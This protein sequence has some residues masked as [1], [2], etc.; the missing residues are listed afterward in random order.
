MATAAPDREPTILAIDIGGTKLA[1]GVVDA[2][3]RVL[4]QQQRSTPIETASAFWAA[5]SGL[6]TDVMTEAGAAGLPLLDAVGVGTGGPMEPEGVTISPLNITGVRDFP[7]L[8]RLRELTGL[9]VFIDN[10]AKALALGEGAFGAARGVGNFIAMVVST[11][12]GGGLVLDGRLVD[13][14]GSNA[15]HI[16]HVNVEPDGRPCV[17]GSHGCLEAEASGTAIAAITGAPAADAPPEIVARTGRLV[18]RAIASVAN[19]CDLQLAVVSGSVAL[20]FGEPFFAAAQAE[21][22]MR[23]QL[24]FSTGT[25]I[26]PGELGPDG[27]LIGAAAVGLRGL[28]VDVLAPTGPAA[29]IHVS[30]R[31][32]AAVERRLRPAPT[33]SWVHLGLGN[34]ARAHVLAYHHQLR[35]LSLD[36][37]WHITAVGLLPIDRPMADAMAAQGNVYT[38]VRWDDGSSR[39]QTVDVIDRYLFAPDD[40]ES[41]LDA[42]A[43]ANIVS[44]T[45]TEG[46]YLVDPLTGIFDTT[47]ADV[48]ADAHRPDGAPPRTWVGFVVEALRRRRAA[49]QPPFTLVSCDNVQHN[50]RVAR[51]AVM[52]FASLVDDELA[53]WL[54]TTM[55]FPCT[56][57][58]RITPV[59]TDDQRAW[60]TETYGVED[61]RPVFSEP[62]GEWHVETIT[63]ERPALARVGVGFAP[64]ETIE[65]IETRKIRLLNGTHQAISYIGLLVGHTFCHEAITDP[66]IGRFAARLMT[67][68]IGPCVEPIPGEP[69]GAN[70]DYAARTRARFGNGRLRDTLDRIATD[71]WI[72]MTRFVHPTIVDQL[73]ADRAIHLLAFTVA[74]WLRALERDSHLV[75]IMGGP[76]QDVLRARVGGGA[77]ASEMLAI[78]DLVPNAVRTGAGDAIGDWFDLIGTR[79]ASEA[80]AALRIAMDRSG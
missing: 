13:G 78:P 9:G 31:T 71:S 66:D 18:G 24:S 50:G 41:V 64:L 36:D 28:G 8:A 39:A 63:T 23:A 59:T 2:S 75:D 6:V 56:M 76:C 34:F 69:G 67:D 3:G 58:D 55:A 22:D 65:A 20:G 27:P 52:G 45:I 32:Q 11:G 12:V 61:L 10:D 57:V 74:S 40:R 42:L 60:L 16:G 25:R 54:D 48:Q 38:W 4:T 53:G 79:G 73:V 80:R 21:I 62:Y 19:L 49:G 72:R 17:C 15:G 33:R 43:T 5:L 7:L 47:D 77:T 26:V 30:R 51:T 29:A 44:M 14:S 68:E 46:A 35:Q 70:E 1:A 37:P